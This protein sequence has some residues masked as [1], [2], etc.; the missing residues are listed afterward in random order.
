[1]YKISREPVN[2]F[3][4]NSQRC[5]WSLAQTSWN[6]KVKGQGQQIQKRHFPPFWRP[7]CGFCLVKHLWP[8]VCWYVS[9][10]I[11]DIIIILLHF[12]WVV[13]D[14]KFI[15]ATC[16]CVCVCVCLSLAACPQYYTDPD[17]TWG[18]VGVPSIVGRIWN[19]CTGFIAMATQPEREMSASACTHSV[20]GVA[21]SNWV[22]YYYCFLVF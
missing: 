17:V 10:N 13:H 19:R 6:V 3:A 15:L 4:P 5:V 16:V 7:A 2:G 11:A 21:V 8:L 1:M 9:V 12:A 20:P 14:A 22:K 18:M